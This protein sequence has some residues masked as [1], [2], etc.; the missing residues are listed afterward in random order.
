MPEVGQQAP[1]FVL[2]STQGQLR[3][4]QVYKARQVILAFYTEDAT[5]SCTQELNSF[6]EEYETIQQLGAEVIAVSVDTL[7]SHQSFC[8]EVG[9]YPFPLASDTKGAVSADFGVLSEDGK[10][11]NRA[12]Y[13]IDQQGL[14]VHA[15]PWYQPNN[16]MQLLE[17]FKALGLEV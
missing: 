13:V 10:R 7:D 4:S 16:P 9:G 1:D 17:V 6:K 15:I 14:I 11:S 3:L 12:V 8:K 2:P 5:P